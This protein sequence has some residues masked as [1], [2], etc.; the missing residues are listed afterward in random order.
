[1]A[2]ELPLL[3]LGV[4]GFADEQLQTLR[5]VLAEGAGTATLWEAGPMDGADAWWINGGRTQVLGVDHIR[6]A[7][8]LAGGRSIQINMGDVDRPLAF[9]SPLPKGFE[10]LCSFD[11]AA[12]ATMKAAL[13]QFESWLAPVT[14]QF[15][16]AS[17]IVDHQ[18]ALGAGQF[19][20]CQGTQ[21]IA[22]VDMQGD[23]AV[24][25]TLGPGDFEDTW[26]RHST[27]GP[28]PEHFAR[29]SL[30]QLM[31]QYTVRTQRDLLPKRYR[32]GL[33]Y[34]RRAPH[35]PQRLIK[36]SHLLIMRELMLAPATFEELQQRC[37]FPQARLAR[38]L[39]SLYFVGSITSNPKRA[40]R[41]APRS[42]GL[43]S[44]PMQSHLDSFMPSELPS[45]RR[46]ATKDLTAPAPLRFDQ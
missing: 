21:V 36:D 42:T 38:E 17:H 39:A 3:R 22:T 40:A 2:L 32:T 30:A 1:M 28:V 14:A 27:S 18:S 5:A 46:P 19:E 9:A 26:W 7:P 13:R 41:I 16:L 31:W 24:R 34:F 23:A 10:A 29:T 12:P 44:G 37:G 15:C 25:S 35:L 11:L 45:T 4:A 33:L 6:V 8:G 43:D 20:L